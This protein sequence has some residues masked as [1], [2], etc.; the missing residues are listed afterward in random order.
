MIAN[1]GITEEHKLQ[2]AQMLQRI[3]A[4][5]FLLYTKNRNYHWNVE[6]NNFV[7]MHE[8]YLCVVKPICRQ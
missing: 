3:L 1:I 7:G 2:A 8:F 5:E 4:N 6:G